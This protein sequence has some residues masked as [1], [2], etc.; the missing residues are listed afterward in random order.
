MPSVSSRTRKTERVGR[1]TEERT[2]M[3]TCTILPVGYEAVISV[4]MQKDRRFAL[5]I[6]GLAGG[7]MLLLLLLGHFLIQPITGL[8]ATEVDSLAEFLM[9]PIVLVVGL[10]LYLILLV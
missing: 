3:K 5:R 8:F 4:D 1:V 10:I 2:T 6:N 9:R 7:L